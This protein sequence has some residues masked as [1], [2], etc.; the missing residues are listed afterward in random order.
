MAARG[1]GP[2]PRG[3]GAG[4][5]SIGA[6]RGQRRRLRGLGVA[7]SNVG[8]RVSSD[9]LGKLQMPSRFGATKQPAIAG[10]LV[11]RGRSAHVQRLAATCRRPSRR[12]SVGSRVLSKRYVEQ[13]AVSEWR[14]AASLASLVHARARRR[15]DPGRPSRAWRDGSALLVPDVGVCLARGSANVADRRCPCTQP[16]D[17]LVARATCSD[18]SALGFVGHAELCPEGGACGSSAQGDAGARPRVVVLEHGYRARV[19]GHGVAGRW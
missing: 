19:Q 1:V 16:L 7:R 9:P 15:R 12:A 4:R 5:C 18:A 11:E 8:G 13:P 17:G 6:H 3:A 2:D 14:E 10:Q